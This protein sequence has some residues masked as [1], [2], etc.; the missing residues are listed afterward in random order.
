MRLSFLL[1]RLAFVI[2]PSA[3]AEWRAAMQAEYQVMDRGRL[4]WS[5]GCLMT[6]TGWR[7]KSGTGYLMGVVSA[8]IVTA[9]I[10]NPVSLILL[11]LHS[12]H[13]PVW[14]PLIY[15][16]ADMPTVLACMALS[17]WRPRYG[18]V[19][20]VLMTGLFF[21]ST[22]GLALL[23][24]RTFSYLHFN[25]MPP[26]IGELLFLGICMTAAFMGRALHWGLFRRG[27]SATL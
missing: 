14:R 2:T 4:S 21:T 10:L 6:A 8:F 22:Y 19:S 16:V 1:M 24:G 11:M 23:A 18:Y 26:V 27:A 15:V 5:L 25:D 13:E 3:R 7:M 17:L 20:A 12:R 9:F